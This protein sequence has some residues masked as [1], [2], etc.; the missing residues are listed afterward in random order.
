M[1]KIC[2]VTFGLRWV[3]YGLASRS[4]RSLSEIS[5]PESMRKAKWG[6]TLHALQA[7]LPMSRKEVEP[8]FPNQ[9][10]Q[11]NISRFVLW[12]SNFN[13]VPGFSYSGD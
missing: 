12:K 4:L 5:E 8:N 10:T 1:V 6:Q 2:F 11:T 7:L 3:V 13:E 9:T